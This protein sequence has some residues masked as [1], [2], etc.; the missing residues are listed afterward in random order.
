VRLEQLLCMLDDLV[1]RI[2]FDRF[3]SEALADDA[4]P[5]G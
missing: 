1:E 2:G 4:R 5:V 3:G